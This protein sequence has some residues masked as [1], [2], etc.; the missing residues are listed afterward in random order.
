MVLVILSRYGIRLSPLCR[1]PI[2]RVFLRSWISTELGKVIVL[3][4]S[5][6]SSVEGFRSRLFGHKEWP[7]RD[8]QTCGNKSFRAV[9][10][11]RQQVTPYFRVKLDGLFNCVLICR[12]L[13]TNCGRTS[14]SASRRQID[15]VATSQATASICIARASLNF[16]IT[17]T[18]SSHVPRVPAIEGTHEGF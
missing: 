16:F 4:K 2:S 8:R 10:S 17:I 9:S 1:R 12:S 7:S 3:E 5:Q 14:L 18:F 11:K 6:A 15:Q 13:P